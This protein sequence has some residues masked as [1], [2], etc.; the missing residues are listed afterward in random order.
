MAY[1]EEISTR[2]DVLPPHYI[3]QCR[4]TTTVKKD[5]VEV[6]SNIR[7]FTKTPDQ[8]VSSEVAEVQKVANALW[9]QAVKDAY[10]ASK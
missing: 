2:V 3:L 7:R 4:E 9:T 5:G 6:G 8:D 1:T 10:T